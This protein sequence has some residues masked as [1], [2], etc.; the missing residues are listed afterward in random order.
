[1]DHVKDFRA[2]FPRSG[3]FGIIFKYTT[4][5]LKF[6]KKLSSKNNLLFYE[7]CLKWLE[8]GLVTLILPGKHFQI[9]FALKI[10]Y[11]FFVNIVGT[12]L[13]TRANKIKQAN[14]QKKLENL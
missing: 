1:M 4:F 9:L 14:R 3:S 6:F 10:K 7:L 12:C 13:C 11:I 8:F 2:F 5:I